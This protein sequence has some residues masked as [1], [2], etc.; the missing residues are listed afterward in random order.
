MQEV[1]H[2][3][4]S[5]WEKIWVV[6][7]THIVE[8]LN[9]GFLGY[10]R[11][12]AVIEV[13]LS[14]K[15]GCFLRWGAIPVM[16]PHLWW[17]Q[18]RMYTGFE[19]LSCHAKAATLQYLWCFV[20]HSDHPRNDFMTAPLIFLMKVDAGLK[21]TGAFIYDNIPKVILHVMIKLYI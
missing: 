8:A 9:D 14:I 5:Y 10:C 15:K 4:A 18:W 20:L 16:D 6:W 2:I 13:T 1:L 12:S 7:V 3:W 21:C 11:P 19:F 17:V